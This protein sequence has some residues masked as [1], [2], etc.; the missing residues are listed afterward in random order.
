MYVFE[1]NFQPPS[2]ELVEEQIKNADFIGYRRNL[3]QI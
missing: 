2:E 1:E 3:V